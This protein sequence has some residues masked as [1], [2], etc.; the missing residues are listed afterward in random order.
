MQILDIPEQVADEILTSTI[1]D[2]DHVE[3]SAKFVL[4]KNFTQKAPTRLLLTRYEF[5]RYA[6]FAKQAAV[7]GDLEVF[8]IARSCVVLF[9]ALFK[10]DE[11]LPD[12]LGDRDNPLGC[13]YEDFERR[14]VRKARKAKEKRR[15][16][17]KVLHSICNTEQRALFNHQD[18]SHGTLQHSNSV[19]LVFRCKILS[20]SCCGYVAGN[21]PSQC[22][23]RL[24]SGT[25]TLLK[26]DFGLSQSK[27][28]S[29]QIVGYSILIREG[30]DKHRSHDST[31]NV[32]IITTF[33]P[34]V[35]LDKAL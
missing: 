7:L 32:V 34:R 25:E 12:P 17:M 1:A 21:A 15:P 29:G 9:V 2:D 10:E 22:V 26:R 30:E 24:P 8:K 19:L 13:K 6:E 3:L 23:K 27:L 11:N 28:Q 5:L 33:S 14:T 4:V 18:L 16:E 35:C 31:P 20:V